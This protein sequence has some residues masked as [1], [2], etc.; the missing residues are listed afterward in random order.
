MRKGILKCDVLNIF[1]LNH[2]L[3]QMHK[4]KAKVVSA[5]DV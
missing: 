2:M 3:M 4:G 5:D 1:P